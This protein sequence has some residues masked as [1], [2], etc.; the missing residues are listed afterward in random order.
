MDGR[1]INTL[2]QDVPMFILQFWILFEGDNE[3]STQIATLISI[4]ATT[5]Q[6]CAVLTSKLTNVRF[7][8]RELTYYK[9]WIQITNPAE[10]PTFKLRTITKELKKIFKLA[11]RL[12]VIL[13]G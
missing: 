6:L 7:S 12:D 11:K 5:L 1:L 8:G 2:I 4:I 9:T 10:D 3:E 13:V